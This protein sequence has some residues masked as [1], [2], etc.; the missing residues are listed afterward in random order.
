MEKTQIRDADEI[1]IRNPAMVCFILHI[2][3]DVYVYILY[4]SLTKTSG[5]TIGMTQ[6]QIRM[7]YNDL[8]PKNRFTSK[9]DRYSIFFPVFGRFLGYTR[10]G[11][12]KRCSHSQ[13]N[14][15]LCWN[16]SVISLPCS[17]TPSIVYLNMALRGDGMI[18]TLQSYFVYSFQQC[19][20]W[21]VLFILFISSLWEM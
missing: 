6:F 2:H 13:G 18:Q 15:H 16:I 20:Q 11:G 21:S 3:L 1:G 19:Y 5:K 4:C 7:G 12:A 17:T 14:R 9:K 10:K 8:F